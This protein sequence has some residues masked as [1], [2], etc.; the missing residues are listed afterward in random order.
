METIRRQPRENHDILVEEI[1]QETVRLGGAD[2]CR[3]MLDRY[4]GKCRK[5]LNRIRK[6]GFDSTLPDMLIRD[7]LPDSSRS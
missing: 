2:R 3:D 6:K 7:V 5:T 4:A 1:R